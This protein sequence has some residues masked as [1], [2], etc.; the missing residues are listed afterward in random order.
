M[1][2]SRRKTRVGIVIDHGDKT[3][4]QGQEM[5]TCQNRRES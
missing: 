4:V 2:R 1:E 3:S 5:E